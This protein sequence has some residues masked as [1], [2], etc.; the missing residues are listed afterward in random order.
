M[1]LCRVCSGAISIAEAKGL[2]KGRIERRGQPANYPFEDSVDT[3]ILAGL[4]IPPYLF[5]ERFVPS[6]FAGV[7][8]KD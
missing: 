7:K 8:R 6:S 3:D 4:I 1:G 2:T 5:L